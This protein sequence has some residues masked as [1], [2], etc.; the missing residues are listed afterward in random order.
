MAGCSQ[1]QKY[2]PL[3]RP[4]KRRAFKVFICKLS[5]IQDDLQHVFSIPLQQRLQERYL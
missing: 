3:V 2:K 4:L 5:G 1:V